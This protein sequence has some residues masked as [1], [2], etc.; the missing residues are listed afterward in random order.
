MFDATGL[1]FD[2]RVGSFF[3][4]NVGYRAGGRAEEV[5][6]DG[7]LVSPCFVFVARC[8]KKF[9]AEGDIVGGRVRYEELVGLLQQRL[10]MGGNGVG[11]EL[12]ETLPDR[13]LGAFE[14]PIDEQGPTTR[15]GRGDFSS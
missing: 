14:C 5:I 9:R 15:M 3:P 12:D 13:C 10:E 6:D 1:L 2:S 4:E 8:Q 7:C 11:V